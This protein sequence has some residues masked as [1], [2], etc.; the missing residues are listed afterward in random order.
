[1]EFRLIVELI[2]IPLAASSLINRKRG[3]NSPLNF[4]ARVLSV[5]DILLIT[6][7]VFLSTA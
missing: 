1:M 3:M 5:D 2:S 6:S 4:A 7:R